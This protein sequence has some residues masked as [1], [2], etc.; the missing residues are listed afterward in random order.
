MTECGS[1]SVLPAMPSSDLMHVPAPLGRLSPLCKLLLLTCMVGGVEGVCPHCYGWLQSCSWS[2]DNKNCPSVSMPSA[3]ALVMTGAAAAG[4]TLTLANLI[5]TRFLR[6]FTRAQLNA[7]QALANRPA[8]GTIFEIQ[9][10]T[11]LEPWQKTNSAGLQV[12]QKCLS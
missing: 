3:N 7:A 12:R 8:P 11:G 10:S 6:I 9:A 4:A 5:S 2:A 1:G